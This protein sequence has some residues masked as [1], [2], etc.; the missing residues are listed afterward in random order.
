MAHE[1][2]ANTPKPSEISDEGFGMFRDVWPIITADSEVTADVIAWEE[3]ALAWA[4]GN[5]D[6]EERYEELTEILESVTYHGIPADEAP[7]LPAELRH[8]P[9]LLGLDLGVSGLVQALSNAGFYPAASCRSHL[10]H[11]W[12]DAPVVLFT[13]DRTRVT[14]LRELAKKHACGLAPN[15]RWEGGLFDLRARSVTTL[16]AIAKDLFADRAAYRRLPK[17]DRKQR[18]ARRRLSPEEQ[19]LERLF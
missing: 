2:E 19:A 10:E 18:A 6:S 16:S 4:D 13:S 11:S 7:E 9:G 5:A 8:G 12:S 17:T 3:Q 15:G 1:G 14:M